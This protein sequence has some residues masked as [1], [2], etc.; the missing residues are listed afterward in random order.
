[1]PRQ[2]HRLCRAGARCGCGAYGMHAHDCEKPWDLRAQDRN[3]RPVS[4][5]A[6]R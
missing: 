1:L 2:W 3:C 6:P 4:E 5:A